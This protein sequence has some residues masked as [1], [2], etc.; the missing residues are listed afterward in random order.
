MRLEK[1]TSGNRLGRICRRAQRALSD[2]DFLEMEHAYA[3]LYFQVLSEA[4]VV[5]GLK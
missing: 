5:K 2:R 3:Y 1:S 4:Y